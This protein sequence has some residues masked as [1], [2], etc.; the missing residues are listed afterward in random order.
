[1]R[2]LATTGLYGIQAIE[3]IKKF[4]KSENTIANSKPVNKKALFKSVPTNGIHTID[5][6]IGEKIKKLP[7]TLISQVIILNI[8][9][10]PEMSVVLLTSLRMDSAVFSPG[11]QWSMVS[12]NTSLKQLISAR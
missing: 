7:Q 10:Y 1:M 2:K 11:P 5:E 12:L 6:V 3:A 9:V 4:K 8:L